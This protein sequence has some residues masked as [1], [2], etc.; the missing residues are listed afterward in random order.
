MFVEERHQEILRLLNE[1][2][3]VKVKELSKRFEVTE[4]CIRKD[5]ASMEAKN[6]L[7]RTYGGAVLPDT[8]HPGHTNIV[9]IRKDKNIKE[10]KINKEEKTSVVKEND[11]ES[12]EENMEKERFLLQITHCL[13]MICQYFLCYKIVIFYPCKNVARGT[14]LS[15]NREWNALSFL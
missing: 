14:L 9:S 4:D 12:E 10:N 7:K 11:E 13:S 1:N 15:M 2:E 8:L 6:L 5:L 3:K